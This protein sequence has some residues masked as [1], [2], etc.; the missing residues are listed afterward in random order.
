MK[1]TDAHLK[2]IYVHAG[3]TYPHECFGYLLGSWRGGGQVEKVR[4]GTNLNQARTD[5]FDMDP[6]EYDRIERAAD[7]AGLS[8]LG[9]YH[10][11]PDW[12]AIPSQTDM[13]WAAGWPEFIYLIVSVHEGRPAHTGVWQL[14]GDEPLRF[15]PAALEIVD[16]DQP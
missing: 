12:P 5:R 9:F 4:R 1:I 10:S 7:E 2:Q 14:A 15:V 13:A 6:R 3:E 8:I 11:H 16:G